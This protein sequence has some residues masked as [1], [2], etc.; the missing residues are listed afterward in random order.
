MLLQ[1]V[2]A[3]KSIKKE[4]KRRKQVSH[5]TVTTEKDRVHWNDSSGKTASSSLPATNEFLAC[6]T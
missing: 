3:E 6:C 2:N 5:C 1:V 4:L